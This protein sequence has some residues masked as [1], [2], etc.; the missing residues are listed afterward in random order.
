MM[1]VL[2][3]KYHLAKYVN[4]NGCVSSLCFAKPRPINLDVALWTNRPEAVT[5]PKCLALLKEHR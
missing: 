4:K 5:C 2:T 1:A 3:K